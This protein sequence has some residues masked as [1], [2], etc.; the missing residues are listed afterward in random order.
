MTW[1][2]YRHRSSNPWTFA[3]NTQRPKQ[4]LI[5]AMGCIQSKDPS[6]NQP[7]RASAKLG[8]NLF[9]IEK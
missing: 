2:V 3:Y 9:T 8:A 6:W 4:I 1:T 5:S 7:S